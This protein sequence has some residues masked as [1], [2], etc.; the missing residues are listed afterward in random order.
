MPSTGGL[1]TPVAP[2]GSYL[3]HLLQALRPEERLREVPDR[4]E[5]TSNSTERVHNSF[6]DTI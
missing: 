1:R 3:A 6:F 2:L 4:A 5:A